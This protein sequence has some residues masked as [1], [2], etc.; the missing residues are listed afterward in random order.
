[1]PVPKTLELTLKKKLLLHLLTKIG[2]LVSI[3][4]KQHFSLKPCLCTVE[5]AGKLCRGG[6]LGSATILV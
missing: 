4:L 5:E 1:M 6:I 2:S 3:V